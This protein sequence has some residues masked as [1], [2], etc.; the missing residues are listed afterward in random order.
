MKRGKLVSAIKFKDQFPEGIQPFIAIVT[1]VEKDGN[2]GYRAIAALLGRGED[3][4][5]DVR[6]DL[7]QELTTNYPL[8]LKLYGCKTRMAELIHALS[9]DGKDTFADYDRWMTMP[10]MG[11]LIA[12]C[13]DV[14]LYHLSSVQCLT[15]LPLRSPPQSLGSRREIAIG[16]VNNSHFVQV[17]NI[18]YYFITLN[19]FLFY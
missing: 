13:Y 2:C 12:S 8:Y 16:F 15:F 4:W 19:F 3:G 6:R 9:L 1:D 7:L 14:V 18:Y 17:I 5:V 10:D 11:H